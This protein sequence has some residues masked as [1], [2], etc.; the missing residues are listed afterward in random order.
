VTK[1]A[2]STA[3]AVS[4]R[5]VDKFA[6]RR[7][8]LADAALL[9]LSELGYARTS[10][11][12][13]AQNSAFSHGVLHYYFTDKV[14]LIT[15]CVRQ[16]KASCVARYDQMFAAATTVTE[17]RDGFAAGLAETLAQDA[18][19]HRLWYDLRAQSLFEPSFRADVAEIDQS[20]ERMVWRVIS[21]LSELTATPP[22]FSSPVSY[23]LFD[24][25]FQQGL[26]KHLSGDLNAAEEFRVAA[27]DVLTRLLP[28]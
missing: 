1:T 27:R 14:D 28:G 23:A 13:I 3:S 4:H 10:L 12:E 21:R 18:T 5:P 16:Y 17:L 26:L 11:R 25:L 6:E 7:D 20:L 15:H 8:Q 9:T 24:G 19:M 22:A 2:G